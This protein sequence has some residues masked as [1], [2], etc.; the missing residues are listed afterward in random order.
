MCGLRSFYVKNRSNT[1]YKML[2][3]PE[4]S[5]I[6]CADFLELT[7]KVLSLVFRVG[8]LH[9]EVSDELR[10]RHHASIG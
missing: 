5:F 1:V 8:H 2:V 10:H 3:P 7:V 6:N 4:V 9:D